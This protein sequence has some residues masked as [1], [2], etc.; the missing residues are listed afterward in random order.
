MFYHRKEFLFTTFWSLYVNY[1]KILYIKI[2]NVLYF[3]NSGGVLIFLCGKYKTVYV[4]NMKNSTILMLQ[5][6]FNLF[7][8]LHHLMPNV[9]SRGMLNFE[10]YDEKKLK[11][12]SI[13]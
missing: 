13:Y 9:T 12:L 8:I 10:Y 5:E 1:I 4:A 3:K 6:D 7:W 11:V 2:I